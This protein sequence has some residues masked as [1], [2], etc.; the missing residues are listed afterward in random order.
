MRKLVKVYGDFDYD[1]FI[2]TMLAEYDNNLITF[3][4]MDL[5]PCLHVERRSGKREWYFADALECCTVRH[6]KPLTESFSSLEELLFA[7]ILNG[8]TIAERYNEIGTCNEFY[9]EDK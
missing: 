1:D 6:P 8:K 5:M 3:N 2:G 7:P 4:G 9:I